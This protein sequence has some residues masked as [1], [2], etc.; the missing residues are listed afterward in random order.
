MSCIVMKERV[1][2]SLGERE[3]HRVGRVAAVQQE[4][5]ASVSAAFSSYITDAF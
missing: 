4:P 5:R 1:K 3:K 2:A